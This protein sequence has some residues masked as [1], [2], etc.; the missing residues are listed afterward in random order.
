MIVV[1]N[2]NEKQIID[3]ANL[4]EKIFSPNNYNEDELKGFSNSHN[5]L[6]Y[7]IYQSDNLVSYA[8]VLNLKNSCEI[9]KIATIFEYRNENYAS[10]I[11]NSIKEKFNQIDIE[12]STNGCTKNFYIK[13]G[14]NE[15][16]VRKKYYYD[17]SD[18]IIMQFKNK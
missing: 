15:L 14:F 18:A 1:N 8:I 13:N 3:I 7:L 12:V 11:L 6:F 5:F 9:Y 17:G 16:Y 10:N 4:E 2:L